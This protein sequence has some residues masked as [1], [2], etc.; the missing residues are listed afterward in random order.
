MKF[1]ELVSLSEDELNHVCFS[2]Y[3]HK[4]QDKFQKIASWQLPQTTWLLRVKEI[5]KS[6]SIMQK[7]AFSEDAEYFRW[8]GKSLV[9][10]EIA[11]GT[12]FKRNFS[13][14]RP[15][16]CADSIKKGLEG[17]A[18]PLVIHG[19]HGLESKYWFQSGVGDNGAARGRTVHDGRSA[20]R[21][22]N[23]H[24]HLAINDLLLF[25]LIWRICVRLLNEEEL[26]KTYVVLQV[27]SL[28]F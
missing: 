5:E 15:A 25:Q 7:K 8:V 4:F 3:F 20:S 22:Q 14:K 2:P 24:Y 1:I 21:C 26:W 27:F 13:V 23:S 9:S 11:Y 17:S 16:D 6:S 18:E 10:S 19:L 12:L 28:F